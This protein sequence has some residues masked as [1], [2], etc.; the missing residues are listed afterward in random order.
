MNFT[1]T[2]KNE[3]HLGS[4]CVVQ[5]FGSILIITFGDEDAT[6]RE[7]LSDHG[8]MGRVHQFLEMNTSSYWAEKIVEFITKKI[9]K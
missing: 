5:R 1:K 9:N 2:F 7:K 3:Y 4:K 8:A 6:H